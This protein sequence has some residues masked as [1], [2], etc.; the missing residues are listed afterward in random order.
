MADTNADMAPS[1]PNVESDAEPGG[2]S[3][4][5]HATFDP[6]LVGLPGFP[7]AL[8]APDDFSRAA[9]IIDARIRELQETQESDREQPRVAVDDEP[10][11]D[12]V[13]GK[14][15]EAD[16]ETEAADSRIPQLEALRVALQR[17]AAIA[18]R[19]REIETALSE[20]QETLIAL[21][22][23]GL[24]SGAPYSV[25]LFDQLLTERALTAHSEEMAERLRSQARQRANSASESL[26]AAVRQR[27]A[28]RG[29]AEQAADGPGR[30]A[31]ELRLEQARL[32][33]L[34]SRQRRDAALLQQ[35]LAA[36]EDALAE[37]QQALLDAKLELVR[38]EVVFTREALDERLAEVASRQQALL[39]QAE[40]LTTAG[41]AAASALFQARLRLQRVEPGENRI[42]LTEGVDAREDQLS[43]ARKSAEYLRQAA[44]LADTARLLLER[45]FALLGDIEVAQW[46]EWLSD[47]EA[48][49]REIDQDKAFIYA[50]L[51]ALR[52]ISLALSRRLAVPDLEP[53]LR[54][55]LSERLAAHDRQQASAAEFLAVLDQVRSLAE[56]LR[57]GLA[58]R[59]SERSLEQRL[60]GA[61]ARAAVWWNHELFAVEDQ[62]VYARD[63]A[64]ALGV[65][66]LALMV[67]S[68]LKSILR[69]SVLPRLVVTDRGQ[70][71]KTR[72]AV[73]SA[74]IRNTSQV[75]VLILAFYLAMAVSGLGQGKIQHWLEI[76][77][78]VALYLQI[79]IWANAGLVDF[80]RR[81][82]SKKER[83]D[84]SAVTGYG[85][86][87]FFL[88]SGIWIIVLISLMAY[89]KYPVAGLVGA[90]GVGGI[91]VA[92]A[93]QN[94]LGDVFSSLAIILDKPFRVGDFVIAGE[95]MGVIEHIGVK[96]T[97]IRSL[98]GELVVMSNTSLLGSCIHNYK[99]MRERRVV[100]KLGVIYQTPAEK[101]ERIPLMI[102]EIIGR[103]AL[104]RFDRAHFAEYG[105]FS[106]NFE[107][108]YYVIGADFTRYM[109]T[110]QAINLAIYRGFQDLG[111][112]F[113]YPTQQVFVSRAPVS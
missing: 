109:D 22:R 20:Q 95:T 94:I 66:L 36:R 10:E 97:R 68:M 104:A 29:R 72:Q 30:D 112:E 43:A 58:P 15:S 50:E 61:K 48:A 32:A 25:T 100:F 71:R 14:P 67:V 56:R 9:A 45:R 35:E 52:S 2:E 39:E 31:L 107:I 86:L 40:T 63:V 55:A 62:G 108:V 103:Q 78:I 8:E 85:L 93:V 102:E 37:A 84:P 88:R 24:D 70:E 74:L 101:L 34:L 79:G 53:E 18:S 44:D 77:L 82:R 6:A 65:F 90:L 81:K 49:I 110:Q 16:S 46:P 91:A 96:T 5:G 113:A 111:V 13:D 89:F 80:F 41:D 69:R 7:A 4:D 12:E 17:T 26:E 64:I 99:H 83:E 60:Q 23:D 47:T 92:F 59:V 57:D 106:L 1:T 76:V 38:A 33:E 54:Q 75:F 51:S 27:R 19:F 28:A 105:D 73:V 42:A 87:L 3:E 98:S 21:E 11:A